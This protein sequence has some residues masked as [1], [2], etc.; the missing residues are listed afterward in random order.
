MMLGEEKSRETWQDAQPEV[1]KDGHSEP[2]QLGSAAGTDG[3]DR[4]NFFVWLLVACS[5]IS[6]L[7]FG[8]SSVQ[9]HSSLLST[10]TYI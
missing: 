6:S 4:I 8:V 3:E 9:F 1:S 10:I 2:P 5:S 7:L